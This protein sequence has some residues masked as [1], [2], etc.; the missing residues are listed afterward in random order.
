MSIEMRIAAARLAV[1][2][3]PKVYGTMPPGQRLARH[4]PSGTGSVLSAGSG[5]RMEQGARGRL[6]S[7]GE[8]AGGVCGFGGWAAAVRVGA[9]ARASSRQM[10]RRSLAALLVAWRRS[11]EVKAEAGAKPGAKPG[12]GVGAGV[13][14]GVGRAAGCGVKRLTRGG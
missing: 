5:W 13:G 1:T 11:D 12:A 4:A 14:V 6:P 2:L 3:G 9:R 8:R 10:V 7:S